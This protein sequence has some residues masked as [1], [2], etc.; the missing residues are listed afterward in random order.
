VWEHL[1]ENMA[2]R[3]RVSAHAQNRKYNFHVFSQA[4]RKLVG[5]V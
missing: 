2:K 4:F 5:R 3:N 1:G